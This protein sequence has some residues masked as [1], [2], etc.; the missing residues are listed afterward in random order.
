MH[1]VKVNN[2]VGRT[3]ERSEQSASVFGAMFAALLIAPY[4]SKVS[5]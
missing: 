1:N 3:Q 4:V 2:P 5:T